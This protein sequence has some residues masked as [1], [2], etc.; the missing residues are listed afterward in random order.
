MLPLY[1]RPLRSGLKDATDLASLSS[2]RVLQTSGASTVK[3]GSPFVMSRVLGT[4]CSALPE[5]PRLRSPLISTYK[6]V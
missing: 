1:N 3:T 4:S 5:D 2:G 6:K